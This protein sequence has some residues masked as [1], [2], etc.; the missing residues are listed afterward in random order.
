[1]RLDS[2]LGFLAPGLGDEV[3]RGLSE[4]GHLEPK[5]RASCPS[6][7]S[8]GHAWSGG[9]DETASWALILRSSLPCVGRASGATGV[10]HEVRRLRMGRLVGVGTVGPL[11]SHMPSFCPSPTTGLRVKEVSWNQDCG[12]DAWTLDLF[13]ILH[14]WEKSPVFKK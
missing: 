8:S 12:W 10:R 4:K 2:V 6:W 3:D 9:I 1:M 7:V 13:L 5:G 14:F 11:V